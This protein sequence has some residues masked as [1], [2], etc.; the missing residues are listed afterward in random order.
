MSRD[1]QCRAQI[2]HE[3][4]T[5]VSSTLWLNCEGETQVYEKYMN[6]LMCSLLHEK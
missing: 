4:K 3:I 5:Y 1:G 6:I 2:N